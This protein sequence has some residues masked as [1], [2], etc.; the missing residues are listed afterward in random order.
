MK[1]KMMK[2][3]RSTSIEISSPKAKDAIKQKTTADFVSSASSQFFDAVVLYT[4][5]FRDPA[6]WKKMRKDRAAGW[7]IGVVNDI[8]KRGKMVV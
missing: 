1:K 8:A 7:H 2:A 6:E 3:L 4:H 5:F